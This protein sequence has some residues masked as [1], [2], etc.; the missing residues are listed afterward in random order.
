MGASVRL[1]ACV[2]RAGI[3]VV[4][5]LLF[6]GTSGDR[7]ASVRSARHAVVAVKGAE[8]APHRRVTRLLG[9]RVVVRTFDGLVLTL[10]IAG[11][12][13]VDG[14]LIFIRAEL[15]RIHASET[16]FAFVNGAGVQI[17]AFRVFHAGRRRQL[18]RYFRGNDTLTFLQFAHIL[19]ENPI[20]HPGI[21]RRSITSNPR[22]RAAHHVR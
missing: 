9:A 7:I 11:T 5:S 12:A 4:A 14:A 8:D 18:F 15:G 10:P 22:I 19:R 6:V 1:R 2:V 13:Q 17:I 20:F 3:A 21:T 16:L